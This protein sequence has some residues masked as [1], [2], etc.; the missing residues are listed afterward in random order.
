MVIVVVLVIVLAGVTAAFAV[1]WSHRGAK[2]ASLSKAVDQFRRKGQNGDG[3]FLRPAAGVYSYRGT[4]T[5]KLSVL[6]T[7][8]HWGP[9]LPSTISHTANGCW[10]Y[11]I[12]YSTH[13]RQD[14]NYCPHGNTLQEVGGRT[15][16][17]FSFVATTL[18]DLELFTCEPPVD[19][20]RL[21]ASPGEQFRQAC[22]GQSVSR[23]TS[24]RTRGTNTYVGPA[25]VRV[26]GAAIPAYHY[27]INRT[28][29]GSQTGTEKTDT[30]FSARDGMPLRV[31]RDIDVE[32][33]SPI[34]A[35][36]YTERGHFVLSSLEPSR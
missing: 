24:V 12:E 27:R 6:A 23:G 18:E 7:T 31:T 29:S 9:E 36:T 13:H 11:R 16:Q 5:E 4:G 10:T 8:Q 14:W 32:S 34:G 25:K 26:G 21:D 17:S 19:A 35:V 3:G 1:A 30:W 20:I 22:E 33:P 28:L 2:E 15:L